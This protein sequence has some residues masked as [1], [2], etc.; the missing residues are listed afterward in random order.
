MNYSPFGT[1]INPELYEDEYAQEYTQDPADELRKEL[2]KCD[3][4]FD[5]YYD[6]DDDYELFGTEDLF[7]SSVPQNQQQPA[8]GKGF[9]KRARF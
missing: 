6:S 8:L 2:R 5:K 9:G 1:S 7:T 4:Q 3:E